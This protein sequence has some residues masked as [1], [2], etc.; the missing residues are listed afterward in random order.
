MIHLWESMFLINKNGVEIL[1]SQGNTQN[2]MIGCM[3]HYILE[4]FVGY[5]TVDKQIQA[6]FLSKMKCDDL[7]NFEFHFIEFLTRPFRLDDPFNPKWK[8]TFL[9]TLQNWFAKKVTKVFPY[10][11]TKYA[12][13]VIRQGLIGEIVSTC[14]QMKMDRVASDSSKGYSYN[15]LCKQY[16]IATGSTSKPRTKKHHEISS[17]PAS[18]F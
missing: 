5:T 4:N 17:P 10:D 15:K 1:H 3:L 8:L 13:G 6:M 12:W 11:M 18:K 9:A 7:T 14:N 2:N 16:H